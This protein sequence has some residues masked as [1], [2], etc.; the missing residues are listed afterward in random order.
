MRQTLELWTN[1]R[2]SPDSGLPQNGREIPCAS[3]HVQGEFR[4]DRRVGCEWTAVGKK[5]KRNKRDVTNFRSSCFP[6]FFSFFSC[7]QPQSWFERLPFL[8]V[9][10]MRHKMG[11]GKEGT[12]VFLHSTNG[13]RATTFP[14]FCLH[15]FDARDLSFPSHFRFHK[16]FRIN[17]FSPELF[18]RILSV[19]L[20]CHNTN[21]L[22]KKDASKGMKTE[23]AR[24]E[25]MR[26]HNKKNE[27]KTTEQ[28]RT[29]H[30]GWEGNRRWKRGE[31]RKNR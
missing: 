28:P 19:S 26:H 24:K 29:W 3:D 9:H 22:A 2:F 30:E 7:L 5:K 31:D 1:R 17:Q 20:D 27:E 6:L 11:A 16:N 15:S 10:M 8:L 18:Y 14:F 25:L 4:I 12:N 23:R 21:P 13:C